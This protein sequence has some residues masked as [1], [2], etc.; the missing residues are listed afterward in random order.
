MNATFVKFFT[1]FNL[2]YVFFNVSS[3]NGQVTPA[4]VVPPPPV[5]I[6]PTLYHVLYPKRIITI[7]QGTPRSDL[8]IGINNGYTVLNQTMEYLDFIGGGKVIIYPGTYVID[9]Q[10]TLISNIQFI[11]SG[12]DKTILKLK[13]FSIFYA[14][15]I[16]NQGFIKASQLDSVFISNLTLDGNRINQVINTN[17]AIDPL[18]PQRR[19]ASGISS[20]GCT[21]LNIVNVKTSNFQGY[22]MIPHGYPTQKVYGKYLNIQNCIAENNG[23]DGFSIYLYKN[24]TMFNN[25][26]YSNDRHGFSISYDTHYLMFQNNSAINNGFNYPNATGCGI[27]LQDGQNGTNVTTTSN[28]IINSTYIYNSSVAGICSEDVFYIQAMN[29][30]ILVSPQCMTF[31]NTQKTIVTN[32]TC[33]KTATSFV[34]DFTSQIIQYNNIFSQSLLNQPPLMLTAGY[35]G[36]NNITLQQGTDVALIL[37]AALDAIAFNGGGQLK[38]SNGLFILGTFLSLSSNTVLTGQGMYNTILKL[39]DNSEPFIQGTKKFS[40]VVHAYNSENITV[41]NLAID[42][43]K[44][45]QLKDE[46][47]AYGKYGFY[48]QACINVTADGVR[49]MNFQSY[50]FDPHGWKNARIWGKHLDILNCLSDNNDW[51]GYALDQTDYINVIN[52]TAKNNGRHGFNVVT[53][54]KYVLIKNCTS[55][56][57]GFYYPNDPA[58]G[59]C[60]VIIQNGMNFGSGYTIVEDVYVRNSTRGG[61]CAND[62]F[63]IEFKNN[64]VNNSTA[65]MNFVNLRDSSVHDNL[66][67]YTNQFILQ[68]NVQNTNIANNTWMQIPVASS[69]SFTNKLSSSILLISILMGY[70]LV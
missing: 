14:N 58:A 68:T 3:I 7:G 10:I 66:C 40:G 67:N 24:A 49:V 70:L 65:C 56:D 60:G 26:A 62:V 34:I 37:Q 27:Q 39:I 13:E 50:G 2:F 54:S 22:G 42:G 5:I 17:L 41:S 38:L 61:L 63:Q 19:G 1:L 8:N 64:V 43:N 55:I 69:S 31:K 59:G 4:P 15:S 46:L 45:N 28:I 16:G 6:Y 29:N 20:I 23:L 36:T 21:R 25:T 52:S 51:D 9:G 53:G 35:D 47:H 33:I 11:G 57:N 48:V 30:N 32:N 12:I 44:D 18:Q